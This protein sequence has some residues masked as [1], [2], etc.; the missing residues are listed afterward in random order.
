MDLH[1]TSCL[2]VGAGNVGRR[3]IATLLKCSPA[4]IL[5]L[6]PCKE[7]IA[8]AQAL[9]PSPV[10]VLCCEARQFSPDDL[11]GI[12]LAFAATP[13]AEVN[14]LVAEACR[15]RGIPCNTSGPALENGGNFI[16]P[17]HIEN[18]PLILAVSTG[19]GSPA[20]ARALRED[21]EHSLDKG[22]PL[23]IRLLE[24]LR[25]RLLALNMGS[26]R[27]AQ[28]FRA[29]CAIPLRLELMDALKCK[30]AGRTDELISPLLPGEIRFSAKEFFDGLD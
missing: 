25:P 21:L 29:L 5:V 11:N 4:K 17:S 22:Y 3:K 7:S 27:D 12:S 1:G 23:L 26:A 30:D 13:A 16:V 24:Y 8:A 28:I 9:D 18:G 15:T 6:D 2:V 19:G 10:S 14:S 20:L